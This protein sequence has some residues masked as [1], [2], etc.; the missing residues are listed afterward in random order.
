M[1]I[2]RRS[3]I[4]VVLVVFIA[5][6]VAYAYLWRTDERAIKRRLGELAQT[7]S[8][9]ADGGDLARVTRI[10]ELRHFFAPD[11]RVTVGSQSLTS[12]D[13]LL[14]LVSRWTPP[15]GGFTVVFADVTVTVDDTDRGADVA[16][17]AMVWSRH[18]ETGEET[19]DAVEA[20]VALSS[21]GGNWVITS[22]E[23]QQTL[24]RP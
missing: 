16:L 7:L 13:A 9:G 20:A 10:A 5:S 19:M 8:A 11:V 3:L 21:T 17:T 4:T 18:A 15:P 6:F 23:S 24:S 2:E 14:A 12:R 22:A 1:Q